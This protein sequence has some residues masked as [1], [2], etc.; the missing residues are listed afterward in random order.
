MT[1]PT[2]LFA[3]VIQTSVVQISSWL[4]S[5]K[6]QQFFEGAERLHQTC[7]KNSVINYLSAGQRWITVNRTLIED[8][9]HV[10]VTTNKRILIESHGA[11]L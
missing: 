11:D 5:H 9:V 3:A 8:H 7:T 1:H 6:I 2:A 4:Y 10:L